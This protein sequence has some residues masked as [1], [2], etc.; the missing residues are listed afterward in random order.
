ME[1]CASV[2][3]ADQLLYRSRLLQS[4]TNTKSFD[5][6]LILATYGGPVET[7]LLIPVYSDTTQLDVELRSVELSCVAINGALVCID[8]AV[9]AR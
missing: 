4:F 9:I 1:H 5:F 6:H 2:D 8:L 7:A 3:L